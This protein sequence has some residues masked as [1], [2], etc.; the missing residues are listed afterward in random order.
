MMALALVWGFSSTASAGHSSGH[1]GYNDSY[2][3]YD[4][5]NNNDTSQNDWGGST[6]YNG[7]YDGGDYHKV[8]EPATLVLMGSGF[9]GLWALRRKHQGRG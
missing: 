5:Q 2:S 6:D 4:S 9:V 7:G 8:P 3:T 1:Y